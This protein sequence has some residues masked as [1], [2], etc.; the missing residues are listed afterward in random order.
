MKIL[1]IGDIVG[2][3]GREA[4]KR[5]VGPLKQELKIDFVIANAENASGGSGITL[6]VATELFSSQVDVLTSGDHIW[7]KPEIFEL[8]NQEE[9]ILRPLNYP[10]GAP[11]RGANIF[12]AKNGLKV[13]VIN[14]N[15]RVFMEALDSPF[16]T[17]LAAYEKLALETKIIILDIHAEATSEK[18]ALGW[19]L[20][21][22]VSAIFG[23]HTHIQTADEKI[24]PKG[25]AYITDV[26]MTGPYDSVI[27]RRV[28]DVLTRFLSSIPVKISVAEENIQLHGALVEI[29]ESTGRAISI[30]R[31]QEKLSRLV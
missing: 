8:I 31:I 25:T 19:Y 5:L 6:K 30:L 29:D 14:V 7:K 10:S 22:K 20:D 12:K 13:G 28:D 21:G 16:K 27:G 24:L 18:V 23:T 17:A 2:S 15:G 26:G 11:G 1:F 3:P 9:R 4:I